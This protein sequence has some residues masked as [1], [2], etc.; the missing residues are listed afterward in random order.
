VPPGQCRRLEFTYDSQG[1]RI[2]KKVYEL[3]VNRWSLA[4]EIRFV[5]AGWNLLAELSSDLRPQAC[6][7][8]GLDLSG[9]LQ[10]AGGV[11]GLL[12]ATERKGS[13]SQRYMAYDGNGNVVALIDAQ[14]G[15]AL[16]RFRYDPFGN[17]LGSSNHRSIRNPFGFSTKY[18]DEETGFLYYGYRYYSPASGK[19]LSRD[20]I[21][22]L[23]SRVLARSGSRFDRFEDKNPYQFTN[24]DGVTAQVLFAG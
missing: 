19:W 1:R 21:N 14:T 3:Q 22:E 6:Y 4:S 11:G 7:V 10:G 8:W 20:P 17:E 13:V 24:N 15:N 9:S 12:M 23:G 18:H 5:Y 16:D 2:G